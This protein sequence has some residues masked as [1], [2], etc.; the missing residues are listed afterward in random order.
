MPSKQLRRRQFPKGVAEKVKFYVYLY[1]D[2]RN[3]RVFYVG[4]GRGNRA[5]SH[6]HDQSES[7]KW[8]RIQQIYKSREQ[9]RIELLCYGL[10][11]SEAELVEAAAIDSIGLRNLCNEVGGPSRGQGR[12]PVEKVIDLC[13]ARPAKI[14][15]MVMLIILKKHYY[16]GIRDNELY[17][18][19][20]GKW[21][22]GHKRE[23]V[24][25]AFAVYRGVV[26][27]VYEVHS[28]HP[29][30]DYPG[31]W[32]FVGKRAQASIRSRYRGKSVER[33]LSRGGR[34]PIRYV[35]Q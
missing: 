14:T 24:E 5:F 25:Y 35:L 26:R 9:P 21:R 18:A 10:K 15:H 13:K 11:K 1:I 3:K 34:N 19:T 8:R 22:V 12:M 32:E 6:L 7:K 27:E 33:Y 28:W 31:R 4:N 2:P 30:K 29:A 17:Q 23:R 20:R 16:Y